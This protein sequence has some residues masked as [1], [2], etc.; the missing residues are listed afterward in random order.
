[1]FFSKKIFIPLAILLIILAHSI[2]HSAGDDFFLEQ[3][4]ELPG[5]I[6]GHQVAD[7][8]GDG[9]ADIALLTSESNAKRIV[10]VYLQRDAD[11]FPPTVSQRFEL[12]PTVDMFQAADL[13]NDG[14]AEIYVIDYD[15]LHQY[16]HD[17]NKFSPQVKSQAP[18]PTLFTGGIEGGI[19]TDRFIHSISGRWVVF[20]PTAEGLLLWNYD[21]GKFNLR[22]KINFPH[23]V[24]RGERSI[25]HFGNYPL[26][27]SMRLPRI[28]IEQRLDRAL[29]YLVWPDRITVFS[30]DDEGKF[31]VGTEIFRFQNASPGNLCQSQL[32]DFDLD[33]RLDLVCCQSRGGIS[34][35]S[36]EINF[37]GSDRISN[38]SAVP[39]HTINLTDACGNLMVDNFDRTGGMEL[40]VPAIEL[41][42][43]ST[44]KMMISKKTDFHVLIYPIDNLGR[45]AKEPLVRRKLSCRLNF[46]L[47]NPLEDIRIDWSGDYNGDGMPDLVLADG[48]GQLMFYRGIAEEYLE[49]KAEQVLD[50]VA[51]D[52]MYSV[53]LNDDGRSD[54]IV[55]HKPDRES[56]RLTLLI[57]NRIM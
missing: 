6:L 37:F 10:Q 29:I 26:V 46:D 55:I 51:P 3:S 2:A 56:T 11:R 4:F 5:V 1:M 57:T 45:P 39:T 47:A 31:R 18:G 22:E 54:L 33:N 50:L 17:G 36:T 7:F 13:D 21:D 44:V 53:D 32:V 35:A 9:R 12:P 15:G 40:A 52:N 16:K 34:G 23:V 49:S 8:N 20:M 24:Y 41:G 28:V 30:E 42:T 48:G 43:M 25:K 14:R 19:L 27:Y 38:L